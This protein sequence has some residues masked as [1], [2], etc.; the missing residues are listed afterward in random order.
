MAG[1]AD[2]ALTVCFSWFLAGAVLSSL[3]SRVDQMQRDSAVKPV[4]DLRN[5]SNQVDCG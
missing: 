2:R 1:G 5:W 4:V 3:V